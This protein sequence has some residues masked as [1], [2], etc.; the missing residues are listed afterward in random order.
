MHPDIVSTVRPSP[1][2]FIQCLHLL[3]LLPC[4]CQTRASTSF[5]SHYEVIHNPGHFRGNGT[6][7][8]AYSQ[9][10]STLASIHSLEI[11]FGLHAG[12]QSSAAYN[13]MD[14]TTEIISRLLSSPPPRF[15]TLFYSEPSPS[16]PPSG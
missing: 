9:S 12:A 14:W 1:L 2:H 7:S 8:A 4:I 13:I 3:Y 5:V 10:Q 11:R 6:L 16:S 15:W